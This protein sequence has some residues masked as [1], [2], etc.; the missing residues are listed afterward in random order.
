MASARV[1]TGA[2]AGLTAGNDARCSPLVRV[3]PA[4][5]YFSSR[6]GTKGTSPCGKDQTLG[7]R[8]SYGVLSTIVVRVDTLAAARIRASSASSSDGVAHPHLQDV[9]LLARHA[10]AGL[11]LGDVGEPVGRVVG[12]RRVDRADRDERGERQAERVGSSRAHVTA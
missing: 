7:G 3:P 5:R 1:D 10:V 11:D 6:S 8:D 12:A 9:V 4:G 2:H